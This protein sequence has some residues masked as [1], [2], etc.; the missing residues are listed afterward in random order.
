MVRIYPNIRPEDH[1]LDVRF[2]E[3]HLIEP[4]I[5][6]LFVGGSEVGPHMIPADVPLCYFSFLI[7]Y[8]VHFLLMLYN[9]YISVALIF[10]KKC[11]VNNHGSKRSCT[12]QMQKVKY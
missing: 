11:I 7:L 2:G 6:T 1:S 3:D 5:R 12:I 10:E 8:D 9:L 4:R